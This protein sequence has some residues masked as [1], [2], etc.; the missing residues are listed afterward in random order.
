MEQPAL[1]SRNCAIILSTSS[2][3]Y[4]RT[5]AY[6]PTERH[7]IEDDT[8]WMGYGS[9]LLAMLMLRRRTGSKEQKLTLL[10][11]AVF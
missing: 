4:R 5:R 6:T 9:G 1:R 3:P 2:P 8:M 7:T 11:T 10:W